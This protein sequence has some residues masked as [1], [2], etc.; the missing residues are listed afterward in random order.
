MKIIKPQDLPFTSNIPEPDPNQG[1]AVYSASTNVTYPFDNSGDA[2]S[3]YY[4]SI[5]GQINTL[6]SGNS[7]ERSRSIYSSNYAKISDSY[8]PNGGAVKVSS[9][10]FTGFTYSDSRGDIV[11]MCVPDED[12]TS[13]LIRRSTDGGQTFTSV[14]ANVYS[15][16]TL[17]FY[18]VNFI[19]DTE[20]YAFAFNENSAVVIVE[21]TDAGAS[22]S[23][24]SVVSGFR[25][26]ED[27]R[28]IKTAFDGTYLCVFTPG[29]TARLD[30]NT[31]NWGLISSNLDPLEGVVCI[32]TCNASGKDGVIYSVFAMDY[33]GI[34]WTKLYRTVDGGE[35]W[36]ESR[37]ILNSF[38]NNWV[39]SLVYIGG[40]YY[41]YFERLSNAARTNFQA[42]TLPIPQKDSCS[43]M[44]LTSTGKIVAVSDGVMFA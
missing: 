2:I 30:P 35:N 39:K 40:G 28:N 12:G 7:L 6:T 23:Q 44:I 1:E 41:Y 4:D 20:A 43:K 25:D 10:T 8:F 21:S 16:P 34:E 15:S 31:G 37:T 17:V 11:L 26:G 5:N 27:I 22:W 19:S 3:A 14:N 13:Q 42:V 36:L 24:S 29:K 33:A 9:D 32:A 38:S 18:Y